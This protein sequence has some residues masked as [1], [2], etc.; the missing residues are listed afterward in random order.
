MANHGDRSLLVRMLLAAVLTPVL[1]IGLLLLVI[2]AL[3]QPILIGVVV[4][5]VLGVG[6]T[7]RERGRT[8]AGAIVGRQAAPELFATVERLCLAADLPR[9]EIVLETQ[10]QPNSWIVQV[11]GTTPRL[12]VTQALLDLLDGDEL[13]AVLAHELS[14]VANHDAAVMT[15]VGM[16]GA[17]LLTGA[18]RA[19]RGGW[20]PLQIGAMIAATRRA[21]LPRRDQR[22]VALARAGGRSRRLRH[23]R[24]A[25][26]AG[27]RVAQGL[28]CPR[29]AAVGRSAR[30]DRAELLP[31]RRRRAAPLEVVRRQSAWR[32][33]SS[34]THPSLDER[35]A[36]LEVLERRR[37]VR[38]PDRRS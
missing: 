37:P 28:R 14:H 30:G 20:L 32:G 2:L 34:A 29:T 24:P 6:G 35:L 31:A 22:V 21:V 38:A 18:R 23:H 36:A 5:L 10:R 4:A 7:V 11:P 9:P 15:V 13:R 19:G 12:H 3:P 27:F 17:L 33:G 8:P 25:F 16:P 1:V 26:R